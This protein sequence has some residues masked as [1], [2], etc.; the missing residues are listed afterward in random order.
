LWSRAAVTWSYYDLR[1][2]MPQDARFY[3]APL[4]IGDHFRED[5]VEQPRRYGILTSGYVTGSNAEA[6]EE[7]TLASERAGYPAVHLCRAR[8]VGADPRT[9]GTG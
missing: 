1:A 6:I 7:A 4:G 3:H 8:P 9:H 5:Y 2:V